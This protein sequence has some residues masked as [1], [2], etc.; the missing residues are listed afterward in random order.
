[1]NLLLVLTLFCLSFP[2][3][4]SAAL[5]EQQ[6][7]DDATALVNLLVHRYGPLPWKRAYLG[8]D[9]DAKANELMEQASVAA[10]DTEFYEQML[11]FLGGFRDAHLAGSIPS[12]KIS[13]LGFSV[14]DFRGTLLITSIDREVLSEKVFPFDIGDRLVRFDGRDVDEVLKEFMHYAVYGY[15]PADRRR[16]AEFLT[17]R[18]QRS[19]PR[20]PTGMAQLVFFSQREGRDKQVMLPWISR[21]FALANFQER[22]TLAK[23]NSPEEIIH[24]EKNH[25]VSIPVRDVQFPLWST[26]VERTK[27]PFVSGVVILDGFRVGYLRLHTWTPSAVGLSSARDI[28]PFLDEEIAFLESSTDAL[29]IDQTNNPGGEVC[30]VERVASYFIQQPALSPEFALKATRPLLLQVEN[31]FV[32]AQEPEEKKQAL[33]LVKKVRRALADGRDLTDPI[34]FC[35]LDSTIRPRV[36]PD[37][38][39]ITYTKPVL[40][41]IN[42][43]CCSGGDLFP[44]LMQDNA[45]AVLFGRRTAGCGGHVETVASL[46]YSDLKVRVTASLMVRPKEIRLSDGMTTRYIEN[47]GV[48]PDIPYVITARDFRDGYEAYRNA[49]KMAVIQLIQDRKQQMTRN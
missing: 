16:A 48:R 37:G 1:M 28:H 45:E 32:N 3:M 14:D 44:A 22:T 35:S 36:T 2:P 8:I 47:V 11:R 33:F 17:F 6:R 9:F 10:N 29:I 19:I 4:A 34:P 18:P 26:F 49:I 40:I 27:A 20:I 12:S 5:T 13:R 30:F 24:D 7:I 15:Y 21:G 46:G 43:L 41:L 39:Q 31:D 23:M 42:E 38:N 25:F